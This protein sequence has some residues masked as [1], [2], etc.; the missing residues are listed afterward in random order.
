ML[1][2]GVVTCTIGDLDGTSSVTVTLTH[3][4]SVAGDATITAS[5]TS[6][7]EPDASAE[8]NN[9]SSVLTKIRSA[10]DSSSG[11]SCSYSPDGSVDP[12]LPGL[13]LASL[14]Y[15]GWRTRKTD[16]E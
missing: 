1:N 3:T 6:T 14:I 11:C 13:L 12:L 4:G 15:L 7:A 5:V 8:P 10:S 9:S 2:S 16:G